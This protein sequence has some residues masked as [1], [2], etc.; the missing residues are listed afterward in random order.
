[1]STTTPTVAVLET[2][3]GWCGLEADRT[4]YFQINGE[5]HTGK[6]LYWFLGHYN[7][8]V[9]NACPETVGRSNDHGNPDKKWLRDN[10]TDLKRI[11]KPELLLVCGTVA[12]RTF[13]DCDFP[14]TNERI[15][16]LPHPAARMWTRDALDE[17]QMLIQK[18]RRNLWLRFAS[19]RFVVSE[20]EMVPL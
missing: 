5:N 11:K 20:L 10:L 18:D 3:W 15:I 1:M 9:T 4:P 17:T 14:I 16:F 6:R 12:Q 2:M 13:C 19:G 7:L 8:L